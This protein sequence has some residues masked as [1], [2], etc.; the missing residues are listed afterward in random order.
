MLTH[1]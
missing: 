1:T